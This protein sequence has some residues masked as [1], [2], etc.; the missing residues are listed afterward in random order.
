MI[1][2]H[3]V[4]GGHMI[5]RNIVRIETLDGMGTGLIYPCCHGNRKGYIIFTN[6]HVLESVSELENIQEQ[7]QIVIYDD[8]GKE[9][10]DRWTFDSSVG[11]SA[12]RGRI[13]SAACVQ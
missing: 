2:N 12:H 13:F 1:R 4:T 5:E 11:A 10:S 6:E 7:I 9:I 8:F 3:N